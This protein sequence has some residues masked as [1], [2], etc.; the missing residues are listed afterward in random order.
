MTAEQN[1][2]SF[3]QL[4]QQF[5]NRP[6]SVRID[7]RRG[8]V[9]D[10][11]LGIADKRPRISLTSSETHREETHIATDSFLFIPPESVETVELRFAVRPTSSSM[12]KERSAGQWRGDALLFHHFL[13]LFALHLFQ[14]REEQQVFFHG[15]FLEEHILK[16]QSYGEREKGMRACLHAEDTS[17]GSSGSDPCRW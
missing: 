6:A 2:S 11:R 14:L 17:R 1:R 16:K 3:L 5:P 12:L 8:F 7:P 10:D 4:H 13:H 9:Q 15:E